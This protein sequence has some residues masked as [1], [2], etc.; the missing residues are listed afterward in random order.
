[1]KNTKEGKNEI[2]AIN[3]FPARDGVLVTEKA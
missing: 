1:M 2:L 3:V